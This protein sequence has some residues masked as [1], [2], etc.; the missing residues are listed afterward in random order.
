MLKSNDLSLSALK[1]K[2]HFPAL[3]NKFNEY[4]SCLVFITVWNAPL[5]NNKTKI[6][7]FMLFQFLKQ[8]S[9]INLYT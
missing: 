9:T 5:H 6:S 3:K 8:L 4:S 1:H 7:C 2:K